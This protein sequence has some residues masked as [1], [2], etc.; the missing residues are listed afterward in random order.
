MRTKA[1]IAPREGIS[2]ARVT[3]IMD[4]L[5]LSAK[6]Q[7]DLLRPP[8]PLGIHSFPERRLRAILR[9]GAEGA[10]IR[11]WQAMLQKLADCGGEWTKIRS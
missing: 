7:S 3:Q 5:E 10:Q 8:A 4:R 11:L 1:K 6:I 9:N 2:R